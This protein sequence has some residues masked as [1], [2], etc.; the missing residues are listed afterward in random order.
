MIPELEARRSAESLAKELLAAHGL[1]EWRV[2]V[3]ADLRASGQC[4]YTRKVISLKLARI[5]GGDRDALRNTILHEVAHALAGPA[6]KH[7]P[8]WRATARA[9]GC[10]AEVGTRYTETVRGVALAQA[11]NR[12]SHDVCT[13]CWLVR[14]ASGECGC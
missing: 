5:V 13:G 8:V 2:V 4:N 1:S 14:S 7:G 9:I 6:A 3:S 11:V 10:N 12:A